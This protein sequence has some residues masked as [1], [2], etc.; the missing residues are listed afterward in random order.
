[1]RCIKTFSHAKEK[2]KQIKNE[3]YYF[4]DLVYFTERVPG[5]SD[6][7]TT[8]ETRVQ[9]ECNTSVTQATRVQ[10]KYDMSYTSAM[11]I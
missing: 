5:T 4:E 11:Q 2:H 10:H 8:G 1:M 3:R 6:T 9:H 7:S